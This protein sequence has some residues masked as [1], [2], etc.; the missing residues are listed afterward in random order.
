[1]VKSFIAFRYGLTSGS[2]QHIQIP[3]TKRLE[4]NKFI[5]KS[6]SG[7]RTAFVY[8]RTRAV[9]V[10]RESLFSSNLFHNDSVT[11]VDQPC[12]FAES[13]SEGTQSTDHLRPLV[14][15]VELIPKSNDTTFC[16][17][18]NR[19]KTSITSIFLSSTCIFH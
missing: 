10:R 14:K 15:L 4:D 2:N 9:T 8:R 11:E 13:E 7:G 19:D 12:S 17:V 5:K 3:T 6:S 16:R 1:M 18:I